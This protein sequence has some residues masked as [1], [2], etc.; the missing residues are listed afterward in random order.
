MRKVGKRC[1]SCAASQVRD[2]VS[3]CGENVVL[4]SM[5]AQLCQCCRCGYDGFEEEFLDSCP[6]G[7]LAVGIMSERQFS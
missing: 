7:L 4:M 5:E 1:P 2:G 6:P 3:I